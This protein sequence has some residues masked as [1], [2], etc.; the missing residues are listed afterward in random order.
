MLSVVTDNQ[1]REDTRSV[2]DELAREGARNMLMAALVAESD[3]YVE[4]FTGELDEN[5]HRLVTR[6]GTAK[7]RT[8]TTV[9]G[10]LKVQAP[11]VDDRRVDE[12][13]NKATFRS[14][15]LP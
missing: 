1:A 2:L 13:G 4:R 12:N 3:A 14:E 7:E 9:A 6:N 8:V 11:R 10:A 5:G 15:I